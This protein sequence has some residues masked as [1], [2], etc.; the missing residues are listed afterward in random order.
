MASF[1]LRRFLELPIT[2]LLASMLLFM[3]M[4]LAPGDPVV[5]ALGANATPQAVA[6]MRA[7]YL[8][9]RPLPTQYIAWLADA[10]RGDLG[11]SILTREPVA[12][13]LIDRSTVTLSLT[14]GASLLFILVSFPLGI[15]AASRRSAGIG[16]DLAAAIGVG[17][18]N[19]LLAVILI[20]VFG[21]HFRW[22]PIAGFAHPSQGLWE[23]TRHLLLPILSLA[24]FY[25]ALTSKLVRLGVDQALGEDYTRTAIAKGVG[26]TGVIV[27]HAARNGLIPATTAAAINVAYLLGGAIVIEE[28]FALPGIGRLLLTAVVNRDFPTIQGIALVSAVVFALS[29][30]AADILVARLDPRVRLR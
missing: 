9:D 15:L 21:L 3:L 22:L 18:P 28:I 23:A 4:H 6:A 17:M 13:M 2:L 30:L 1:L 10:V 27:K 24:A 7:E 19:F 20:G 25:I 8:L 12:Q 5:N 26:R 16:L 29:S 11:R 14:L